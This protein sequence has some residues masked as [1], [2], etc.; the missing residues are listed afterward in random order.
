M[1]FESNNDLSRDIA[2]TKSDLPPLLDDYVRVVHITSPQ[3]AAKIIDNGLDYE[4]QGMAMSSARAWSNPEDVQYGSTDPRFNILGQKVVV[5]DIP[6]NEWKLHNDV[7]RSPGRISA[8]RV[9]GVIDI[10]KVK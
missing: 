7:T 6:N 5:M 10:E 4:R 9:V 3:N 8:Y 1:E 2:Y